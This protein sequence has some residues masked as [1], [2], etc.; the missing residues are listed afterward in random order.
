MQFKVQVSNENV[1]RFERDL[2]RLFGCSL[3]D[4]LVAEY[5][6]DFRTTF[7]LDVVDDSEQELVEGLVEL[8]ED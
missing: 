1:K 5:E 6:G 2:E 8:I 3:N 7:E 4:L